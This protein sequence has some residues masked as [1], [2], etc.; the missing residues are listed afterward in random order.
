M[1]PVTTASDRQPLLSF[2]GS[3]P[4]EAFDGSDLNSRGIPLHPTDSDRQ[5]VQTSHVTNPKP[6]FQRSR[7]HPTINERI[8]EKED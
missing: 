1:K 3:S 5:P 6:P 8:G 2:S 7:M 4:I